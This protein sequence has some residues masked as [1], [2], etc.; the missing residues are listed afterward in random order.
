MSNT[1]SI[2]GSQRKSLAQQLDRLDGIIDALAE[3]LNEAVA[4]AVRQAVTAPVQQSVEAVLR[5][6]LSRPELLRAL[7]G[8]PAVP[9]AQVAT[10]VEAPVSGPSLPRRVCS[11]LWNKVTWTASS[12]WDMA[13][14]KALVLAL[15]AVLLFHKARQS[16]E[17]AGSALWAG[18]CWV[19]Q[20]PL[21]VLLA[22]A[23]G[24]VLGVG[25]YLTGPLVASVVTGVAGVL[26][27]LVPA[28]RLLHGCP[29]V[30]SEE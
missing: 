28:F 1:S 21:V 17:R 16:G 26:T 23:T 2:N 18:V 15:L 19:G 29:A 12:L 24:L 6:V 14:Q 20:H 11:W 30:E 7:A 27:S 22:V 8:H 10:T 4:D 3:G 9:V 25:A 13:A 5:E